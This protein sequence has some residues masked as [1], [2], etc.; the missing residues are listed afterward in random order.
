MRIATI[1]LT[2][3][4]AGCQGLS[5]FDRWAAESVLSI[6]PL[7]DTYQRCTATT[8][9]QVLLHSVEQ[10]ERATLEGSEPPD[11]MKQWGDHVM[12]QP[13]RTTV[14]PRMLSAACTMRTAFV[15]TEQ[16]R[17][18]EAIT[19]Y[20]RVIAHYPDRELH[21]YVAQA[22]EALAMLPTAEPALLARR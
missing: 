14:D 18:A 3:I 8:D 2:V 15:L 1:V 11:W 17:V 5:P 12:R 21:Y 13:L 19:L 9:V 6:M 22:K 16:A 4:L 20:R 7:W 10:L